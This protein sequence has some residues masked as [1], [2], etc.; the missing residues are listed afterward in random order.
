MSF[1]DNGAQETDTVA[2]NT[3]FAFPTGGVSTFTV[4]GIDRPIASIRPIQPLLSPA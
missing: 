4:T 2:P 1:L 3:V